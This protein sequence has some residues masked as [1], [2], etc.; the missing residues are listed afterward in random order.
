MHT[1]KFSPNFR[2]K[3]FR[4][5]KEFWRTAKF[6]K[7]TWEHTNAYPMLPA[8]GRGNTPPHPKPQKCCRKMKRHTRPEIQ[9]ISKN[10]RQYL[11]MVNFPLNYQT[12]TLWLNI[13]K[14]SLI[15]KKFEKISGVRGEGLWSAHGPSM[16]PPHYK[17]S[18]AGPLFAPHHRRKIPMGD[19]DDIVRLLKWGPK[20]SETSTNNCKNSRYWNSPRIKC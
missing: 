4:K 6:F 20:K 18:S 1:S 17:P 5:F 12:I 13:G 14:F 10:A 11:K 3:S 16:R 19:T 8:G 15:Y 9:I 2:W 7:E